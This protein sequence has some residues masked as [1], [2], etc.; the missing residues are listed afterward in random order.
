M[1]F[2]VSR[3]SEEEMAALRRAA[4]GV[5]ILTARTREEALALVPEADALYGH[6]QPE[7]IRA[8]RKLRWAQA[9]SAGV[10]RFLF[11]EIR[12]SDI[13][14]TN[15]R[16]VYG[17]AMADHTMAFILAFARGLPTYV[18]RQVEGRWEKSPAVPS[19]DL[20]GRTLLIA[21]LGSIGRELAPR[22]AA[23]GVR[24]IATRKRAEDPTPGVEAVHPPSELRRLLPEADFVAVCVALTP[25]TRHL[26]GAEEFRLM[27]PTA[28]L[29]NVTR[30]AVLDQEALVAA[31]QAGEIAGAGLDVTDPEPLPPGHVLWSME[32][33]ILTP[34]TSGRGPG[35][36]RRMWE[37]VCENLRRFAAGEPLLNVVDKEAGY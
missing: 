16:N 3:L 14:L 34:H 35:S 30:G 29:T 33:V 24:V 37:V 8:G 7:I 18:R 1:K 17:P 22:A 20:E 28:Y 4:P 13:T 31:L 11:P 36:R 26:F 19:F 27:K 6:I 25:E 9:G 32:N 2:L 15:A 10:E 5:E 23:F 12:E 21:G